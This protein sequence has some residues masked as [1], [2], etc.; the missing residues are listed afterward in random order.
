MTAKVEPIGLLLNSDYGTGC[1]WDRVELLFLGQLQRS[2]LWVSGP[3][4]KLQ[5]RNSGDTVVV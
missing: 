3:L 4:M 5:G 2:G 1:V